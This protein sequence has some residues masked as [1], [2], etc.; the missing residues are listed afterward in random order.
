MKNLSNFENE[1]LWYKDAIIY[2]LHVKS[3]YDSNDDGIGDFK[4]LTKKLNYIANLGVTA[5]WLLPFY[6]SPLKDD[7]YDI[8]DYMNIH[9]NY[10]TLKDFKEFLKEAHKRKIRVITEL[11][12]NH[13]SDQHPW[14]KKSRKSG[15]GSIFRDFYV[16]SGTPDKYKD[17]RIIFK[18]FENSNWAWDPVS[19]AY[20]WHRFYSHQPDLNF[21]SPCV[22]KAILKVIKYW[23]D[24]GVD[25][26]RI[27]AI[28]YLF[29]RE[30]TNC[31]NLPETYSYLKNIRSYI[32]KHYSDRMLLA[33]ANQWPEDAA[34][35]FG[36]GDM[37]QMV[38][39]FPLM[40]RMFMSVWMEDRFPIID[41]FDQTPAIPEN[42]QW[43]LFLRNHDELTL[44]MVSDEE[45]DYMNRVFA[46]DQTAK[47]NLGIKRRLAPLLVNNRRKIEL[48][49]ILL[50]SLPGTPIIY[51]G[52]EICMGD[53]HY[54]GDRNGIRTPMQWSADRNAGF[55]KANP[56]KLFLPIIIDPE[57]H[58]EAVNVDNMEKNPSSFL[59]WT[60]RV[61]AMRKRFKS[62]GRGSIEFLFPDNPNIL[63]FTRSYKDEII[64]VVVNLSRFSQVVE[65][66]LSKFAGYIPEEMFSRN[67][68]PV[69]KETPYILTLSVHDYY[70]FQLRKEDEVIIIEKRHSLAE[71]TTG[72]D[73]KSVFKDKLKERLENEILPS[74][75]K[76]CRWFGGKARK[77]LQTKIVDYISL[78]NSPSDS[79]ILF[80]EIS[81]SGSTPDTYFL[82][83]SFCSGDKAERIVLEMPGA[84]VARIKGINTEGIIYDAVYD[85]NFRKDLLLTI[86][87]KIKLKGPNGYAIGY[88]GK[89]FNNYT[90]ELPL[91]KTSV[92]KGEQSNTSI[93]YD[94][95]FFF[96]LY[97]RV[98]EGINPELEIVKFLTDKISFH[99]I[100][101]FVGAIEYKKPN[102]EPIVL[103]LLQT[104]VPNQ[105]D[106]WTY[107]L[108]SIGR[109]FDAVLSK[110]SQPEKIPKPPIHFWELTS[111]GIPPAVQE[112]MGGLSLETA[113]LLG[114]RTAELH[115]ALFSE[116]DNVSFT[117]EPFSVLSQRSLYQSMLNHSKRVF[118]LL[119]KNINNIPG[120][121]KEEAKNILDSETKILN[122]FKPLLKKKLSGMNMRIHG[123]YHLGQ[124]LYTGNDFYIIDF[125]GEP[126]R[127]FSERRLKNSP[128]KDIA[129]MI[130]S[131]HYAVYTSLW[132][133][134]TI[135]PKD[136][137]TLEPWADIWYKYTAGIFFRSYLDTVKEAPFIPKDKE[138]LHTLLRV[139]LLEKAIYEIGYEMNSRP[140][141]L[142]VPI[143]AIKSL[144]D[145]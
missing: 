114:K 12:L 133:H 121:I 103:G 2:E 75:V 105:G 3:F 107:V 34:G 100:S 130:R 56:Q 113:V 101:H 89:F 69:I 30:G 108:D 116:T 140:D 32:D 92:L 132:K 112:L 11:V 5:I 49:N 61:I 96:K 4:G 128:V 14:F 6:P 129:G 73:W 25:G 43:A 59:W 57:Y 115:L 99:N 66:N 135:R 122:C 71:I 62:F 104:L 91:E 27:D 18:D 70:W 77:I 23:L 88:C 10:G 67:R 52:D 54:L 72:G 24:L 111:R 50:N 81:Y 124:I 74:Y 33:E 95:E 8:S 127:P 78:E 118:E 110:I 139:F 119:R 39:H 82:P 142:I 26:M 120:N 106:A 48:L 109:Y 63:A 98:S 15:K 102:S 17:A 131:F 7:G 9:P 19:K 38:F 60:R 117:P 42:S 136:I 85:E 141:W 22:Q 53:N 44:E 29:E 134:L 58:Y 83:L 36:S 46:K 35:Y 55:S 144:M 79:Q 37:C 45:R 86:K 125:E 94:N 1:P 16:W 20:Y 80:I 123:D 137:K 84:V 97:R 47:I 76:E 145:D 28:P 143:N 31:E 65:L 87:N 41:I 21:D 126:L 68:F 90:K 138:E 40:P 64:L 13:T 51:Y 93:L